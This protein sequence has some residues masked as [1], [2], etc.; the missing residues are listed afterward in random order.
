V[1]ARA[2]TSSDAGV[3]A[4]IY[5]EG[6]EDRIGTFETRRRSAADIAAWFDGVHPVVV[7][8]EAG[9]VIAFASTSAYRARECYAKIAEFSVYVARA[10][11]GTGAGRA[12][13]AALAAAAVESG[14]HKLVSRIFP[15]NA[16]SRA[17]C[18]ALGF[19]EVGVYH[20]HGQLEGVWRDC[21]I[22]ERL[23]GPHGEGEAAGQAR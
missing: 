21:V 9:A 18:R 11:R 20:E 5:N 19:R 15:E 2:A 7:V 6:I 4:R 13:L 17:M 10:R 8:E 1:R 16:A 12:A 3:I 23:L 22:V 14:L